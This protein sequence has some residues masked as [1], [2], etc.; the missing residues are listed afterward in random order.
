M[1]G[2]GNKSVTDLA[3]QNFEHEKFLETY[4]KIYVQKLKTKTKKSKQRPPLLF[5]GRGIR[6]ISHISSLCYICCIS[7]KTR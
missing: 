5:K 6:I 1:V 3:G 4:L 2:I 7:A